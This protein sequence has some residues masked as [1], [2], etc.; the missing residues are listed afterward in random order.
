MIILNDRIFYINE[1]LARKIAQIFGILPEKRI[2]E[3]N[4][5][6]VLIS[7]FKFVMGTNIQSFYRQLLILGIT[8][9]FIFWDKSIVESLSGDLS[10]LTFLIIALFFVANFIPLSRS[11]FENLPRY[12][13]QIYSRFGKISLPYMKDLDRF[14]QVIKEA[15]SND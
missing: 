5:E 13:L 2:D 10:D 6:Y 8:M 9:Y 4:L 15:K 3:V 12:S 7:K 11:I 1:I 14:N